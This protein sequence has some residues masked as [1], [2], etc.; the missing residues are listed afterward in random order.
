MSAN[1]G[2]MPSADKTATPMTP[3]T[4]ISTPDDLPTARPA[5]VGRQAASAG[6]LRSI[7]LARSQARATR[8]TVA[9]SKL[10]PAN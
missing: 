8:S 2:A 10:R 5:G 1:A 9:S 3:A 4:R 6:R 7:P